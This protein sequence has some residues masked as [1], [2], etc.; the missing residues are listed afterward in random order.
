MLEFPKRRRRWKRRRGGGDGGG[1]S[2]DGRNVT[3]EKIPKCEDV[4]HTV[5]DKTKCT[6]YIV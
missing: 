6:S 1:I 5:L 3:L 2:G 4:I